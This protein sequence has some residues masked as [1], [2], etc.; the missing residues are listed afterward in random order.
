MTLRRHVCGAAA[1]ARTEREFFDRLA[2]AG[3]LVRRRYSAQH[4]GQVSGY[5]VGLPYHRGRDGG[6]IWY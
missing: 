4:P 6:V 5:A 2:S 1:G 3:V